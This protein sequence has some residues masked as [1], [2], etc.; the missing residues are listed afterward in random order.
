MTRVTVVRRGGRGGGGE[1]RR[2]DEGLRGVR[3]YGGLVGQEGLGHLAVVV[4]EDVG[5]AVELQ[6]LP[7]HTTYHRT[8][9]H[10]YTEIAIRTCTTAIAHGGK[11]ATGGIWT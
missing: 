8:P 1:A 7:Y 3:Q 4:E 11:G 9:P 2:T 10:S 6:K 5:D